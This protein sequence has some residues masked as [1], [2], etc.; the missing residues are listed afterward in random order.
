MSGLREGAWKRKERERE[1]ERGR[2]RERERLDR[3]DVENEKLTALDMSRKTQI[4]PP[5]CRSRRLPPSSRSRLVFEMQLS[6][7][8]VH[9]MSSRGY[10]GRSRTKPAFAAPESSPN[11][12]S[13]TS[14]AASRPQSPRRLALR[15]P[16]PPPPG[17]DAQVALIDARPLSR[18]VLA[19]FRSKM[20]LALE[21]EDS[22]EPRGSYE[23]IVDLTRRLNALAPSET[24]ARTRGILR[25]LFPP[26][27]PAAFAV[28]FSRPLPYAS[29]RINAEATALACEWLMG[30]TEVND[31]G[32]G[33]AAGAGGG[34]AGSSPL[35][36]A[37][38][39]T[40]CKV[41]Y[42]RYLA[43]TNC[44]SACL[45]SCKLPT[46]SFFAND[47]GLPLRMSPNLDDFSCQ[48][49]FGV[50]PDLEEDLA[51]VAGSSCLEGCSVLS[52]SSS[53]GSS[54]SSSG[55]DLCPGSCALRGECGKG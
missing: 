7:P 13:S 45:N 40:G 30:P 2:E 4:S 53:G 14:A 9:L 22:A 35:G 32:G 52:S 46:Q 27:L 12:L 42:C 38:R 31:G 23:A 39:R 19:L 11:S 34:A 33:S 41:A 1:R 16:P 48:F 3:V 28:L 54:S 6:T 24:A 47:M 17:W 44:V 55:G 8:R 25:S 21:G 50:A 43:S 10:R 18:L 29:A 26:W 36:G 51:L 20:A 15:S 49:S 37:G 5:R